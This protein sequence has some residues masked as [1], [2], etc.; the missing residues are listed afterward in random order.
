MLSQG[1]SVLSSP[2]SG[3]ASSQNWDSVLS[4]CFCSGSCCSAAN[5]HVCFL[6]IFFVDFFWGDF[7]ASECFHQKYSAIGGLKELK[8]CNLWFVS[9]S[10]QRS[11]RGSSSQHAADVDVLRAGPGFEPRC[12]EIQRAPGRARQLPYNRYWPPGCCRSWGLFGLSH[13]CE[14]SGRQVPKWKLMGCWYL[15]HGVAFWTVRCEG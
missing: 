2:A 6:W 1:I 15:G 5:V 10:R 7:S 9:G 8:S 13:R 12:E 11:H 4:R 3:R 14:L